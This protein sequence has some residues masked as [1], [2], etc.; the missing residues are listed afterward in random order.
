ME[1]NSRATWIETGHDSVFYNSADDR[2]NRGEYELAEFVADL[3]PG[4]EVVITMGPHRAYDI[5]YEL[6]VD[7]KVIHLDCYSAGMAVYGPDVP[8]RKAH[9]AVEHA[10]ALL[11]EIAEGIKEVDAGFD[12]QDP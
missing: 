11:D 12:L 2:Y 7:E 1:L 5:R 9:P 10:E 6:L 3:I 4:W 8:H